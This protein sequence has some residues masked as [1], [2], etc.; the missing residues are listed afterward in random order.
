MCASSIAVGAISEDRIWFERVSD[1][2]VDL[3]WRDSHGTRS[4]FETGP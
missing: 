4:Y 1:S 2:P 3:V